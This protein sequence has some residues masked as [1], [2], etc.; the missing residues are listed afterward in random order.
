MNKLKKNF[1]SKNARNLNPGIGYLFNPFFELDKTSL[2]KR[3]ERAANFNRIWNDIVRK[4]SFDSGYCH[5]LGE[6]NMWIILRN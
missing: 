5:Y 1:D 4:T 2:G 3:P 6:R